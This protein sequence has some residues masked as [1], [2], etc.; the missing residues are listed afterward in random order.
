MRALSMTPQIFSEI[1]NSR[2]KLSRAMSAVW[3]SAEAMAFD[4]ADIGI[5]RDPRTC[6][7]WRNGNT[8]PR[9]SEAEAI[10]KLIRQIGEQKI[11]ALRELVEAI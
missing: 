5:V 4:L 11:N 6:Q 7:N 3:P 1:R 2:R 10:R 8:E 9:A